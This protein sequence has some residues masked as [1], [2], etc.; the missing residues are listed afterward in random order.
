MTRSHVLA[1]LLLFAIMPAAALAADAQ[2]YSHEITPSHSHQIESLELQFLATK[3]PEQRNHIVGELKTLIDA[4]NKPENNE[5]DGLASA[6]TGSLGGSLTGILA[7]SLTSS[8]TG[9]PSEDAVAV[10]RAVT[11]MLPEAD[12]GEEAEQ[13]LEIAAAHPADSLAG[14]KNLPKDTEFLVDAR[15][16]ARAARR[17]EGDV[18]ALAD[19]RI[20][21]LRKDSLGRDGLTLAHV[22]QVWR[23]NST[24]G[25]RSFSPR[26][27]MYA[28]MSETLYMVRARVLKHSG[29]ETE[30]TASADEPVLERGSSMYFDSRE[31]ELHFSKL[32]PGDLVEVEYDLLPAT[33]LNPWAGYYARLDLFRD[34][35][36][37][38]LRRR[39]V[40]ASESMKL[41]AVEHGLQPAV[42][43]KTSDEITRIW[44]ARDIS[45]QAFEAFSPGASASG[46][47]LHVSSI[48]SMEEFGHW[49]S[50]MLESGLELDENLRTVAR[51]I[52]ERNLT[53]QQKAEAVYE[54]VQ[55]STKYVAFEF[56]VHSYQPYSVSTVEKRGFGD[57]KDKAAMLV[58]LLRAVGVPAE[59]AMVRTR[60]A[61]NVAAE[62]YSVQL[63]NHAMAYVPELKLY[64]DGTA[65]YA[66]LGELP[67]DD[68]GAM[69]MT[70]DSEGKATWRTV[71]FSSPK[72]N[73]VTRE[74]KA[75]LSR[76]GQVEFASQT[77]F[78][79]YFAA[80]QRRA[81]ESKDLAG[82]YR[83]TLAQ[84]Y[85]TVKI[86]HAV[87]EGTARASRE[88]DLRIEGSIDAAHGEHE[89]TLRSS[90]NTAGLMKKYA[91]SRVRRNPVL[92]PVTPSEHEVFDYELPEGAEASLPADT[93]LHTAFG[94]VEVSYKRNGLKLRVETY[95]E[96]IPL[97]VGTGDYAGFRAFCRSA[98]EAL[99]QEVR[100]V[101]P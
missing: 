8:V 58:A 33:E 95:T 30:A 98:D 12:S 52:L 32:E 85:P 54:S 2:S 90:L 23:I 50:A 42:V 40:I 29:I 96:L 5:E 77:K 94:S 44:E 4:K 88:V 69:A 46:P 47:Y 6:Q 100:I 31:R 51:Q 66:A 10:N 24:Q 21:H 45:A 56:G 15:Q 27:V 70:V 20:D 72:A 86:A 84:F 34:S 73:R 25:A 89:V 71:P 36:P 11:A 60:S 9:N 1:G 22:Q 48:G 92:V 76:E 78:E 59:F 97:T 35:F 38:R 75:R 99:Q 81:S 26:S 68:Q 65:E 43:R 49:Y 93:E 91:P 28:S 14:G 80:E 37:T 79:G 63:F 87:A 67:S 55:R 7:G 74:V 57:C 62:A 3:N 64:M 39:V 53:T 82:S 101:L 41:Y 19:I 18:E 16:A 61:G 83:A 17:A 13:L